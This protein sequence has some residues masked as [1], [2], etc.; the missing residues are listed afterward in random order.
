MQDIQIRLAGLWVA[1][2][3]TYLLGDVLRIYAGDFKPGEIGGVKLSDAMLV[4][5]A[6]LMVIPIVMVVLSLTT[7]QPINRWANLVA[8]IGL[9]AFNLIGLPGYPG[10][11]DRF[12]I[13]V[14]LGW[15]ALTVWIAWTWT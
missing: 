9:F 13:V 2:M 11:Y 3:L 7:G 10:L 14:G 12:L 1:L 15:N 8:A 6:V 4:G 5:I